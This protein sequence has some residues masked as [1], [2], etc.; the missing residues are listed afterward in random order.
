M[1]ISDTKLVV[2]S[3][4]DIIVCVGTPSQNTIQSD[5]EELL[6][7]VKEH[8]KRRTAVP[9]I[10]GRPHLLFVADPSSYLGIA[11]AMFA[12]NPG[13][14]LLLEGPDRLLFELRE[15]STEG[16]GFLFR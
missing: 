4:D 13:Q 8:L 11:A 14:S 1:T 2:R 6:K 3:K 16:I 10:A 9:L 5:N 12:P 7:E 15:F